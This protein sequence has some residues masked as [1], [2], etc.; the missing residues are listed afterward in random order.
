M[1]II[2]SKIYIFWIFFF[3]VL[4]VLS[5]FFSFSVVFA[6]KIVEFKTDIIYKTQLCEVIIVI[7]IFL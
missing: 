7:K 6:M 5:I 3:C 1:R 2:Y 4:K